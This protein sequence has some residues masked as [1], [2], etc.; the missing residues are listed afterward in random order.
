MI[1][2]LLRRIVDWVSTLTKTYTHLKSD[3][4]CA[5]CIRALP[6][7]S[8]RWGT[9]FPIVNRSRCG[10]LLC[11]HLV[12]IQHILT[13]TSQHPARAWASRQCQRRHRLQK[14]YAICTTISSIQRPSIP[15]IIRGFEILLK[16]FLQYPRRTNRE[17]R[18]FVIKLWSKIRID[19]LD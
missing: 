17:V 8:G 3:S 14:Y 19:L 11:G 12:T 7:L 13:A 1:G 2:N 18:V 10:L 4:R 6:A 15:R 5:E 16:T 9:L